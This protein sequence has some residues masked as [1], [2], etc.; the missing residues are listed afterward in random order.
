MTTMQLV[1]MVAGGAALAVVGLAL[2]FLVGMRTKNRRVQGAVIRFTRDV[3]NPRMLGTAGAPGAY[4]A[5]IRVRGRTSGR[6][7][8][9]PVGAV[10]H[11]DGFLVSLPYGTRPQWLRNLLAA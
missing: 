8:D 3:M 7:I 4:A 11:E 1:A 5:I 2:T 9:T 6:L 10:P